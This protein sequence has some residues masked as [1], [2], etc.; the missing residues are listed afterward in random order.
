MKKKK[1]K[2]KPECTEV[3]CKHKRQKQL[4]VYGSFKHWHPGVG[5]LPL[6]EEDLIQK[7]I[8][9]HCD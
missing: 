3:K 8:V 2:E 6:W 5:G 4:Y 9:V 7:Y 1:E